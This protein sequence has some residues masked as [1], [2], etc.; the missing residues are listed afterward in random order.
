MVVLVHV[1]GDDVHHHLTDQDVDDYDARE[2][3]QEAIH[4]DQVLNRLLRKEDLLLINDKTIKEDDAWPQQ[5]IKYVKEPKLII[6]QEI[7]GE[8][9]EEQ[10]NDHDHCERRGH[11]LTSEFLHSLDDSQ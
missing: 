11:S 7:V 2:R 1:D 5:R 8:E 4:P 10:V 3:Q 6:G 9:T